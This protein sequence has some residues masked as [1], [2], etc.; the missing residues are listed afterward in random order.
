M[1]SDAV[2]AYSIAIIAGAPYAQLLSRSLLAWPLIFL[3]FSL[4]A[5]NFLINLGYVSGAGPVLTFARIAPI[6]AG[7]YEREREILMNFL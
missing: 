7:I 3:L 2:D 5:S 4:P 6:A 1:T